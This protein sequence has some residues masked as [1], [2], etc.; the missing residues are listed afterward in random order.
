[1]ELNNKILKSMP[2]VVQSH[3]NML[4]NIIQRMSSN[5][6]SCKTWC[7]TLVT[8]LTVFFNKN[9]NTNVFYIF[10]I[11]II[12]FFFLDVYYLWLEKRFRDSH[13]NFI[14]KIHEETLNIN[15]LFILTPSNNRFKLFI[16]ALISI[17]TWP[18]YLTLTIFVII[19]FNCL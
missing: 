16:K 1:M 7:I 2:E 17:S 11:P 6:A 3:I 12:L 14:K 9:L 19:I 18:F 4:Q 15:D 5:C 13:N 8:G 10:L